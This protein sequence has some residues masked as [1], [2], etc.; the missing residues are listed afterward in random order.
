MRL[1]GARVKK[2]TT[3]AKASCNKA[4]A[5]EEQLALIAHLTY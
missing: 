3:T 5:Y 4:A 1:M 2:K